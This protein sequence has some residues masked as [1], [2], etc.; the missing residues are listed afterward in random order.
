[1]QWI[2][3]RVHEGDTNY[4]KLFDTFEE[5]VIFCQSVQSVQ[6]LLR[7]RWVLFKSIKRLFNAGIVF[8]LCHA[9]P[10]NRIEHIHVDFVVY[11]LILLGNLK[12]HKEDQALIVCN[13]THQQSSLNFSVTRRSFSVRTKSFEK[14]QNIDI[15]EVKQP[16]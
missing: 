11:L 16:K 3:V 15:F 6:V 9:R 13:R 5:T 4:E 12:C 2:N 10:L 8:M 14:R 1:M 7:V